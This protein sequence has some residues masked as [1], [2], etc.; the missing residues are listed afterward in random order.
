MAREEK[1]DIRHARNGQEVMIGGL[2]VDGFCQENNTVYEY[3]GC[4][5]LTLP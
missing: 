5:S 1:L 4:K 3:Q 2:K